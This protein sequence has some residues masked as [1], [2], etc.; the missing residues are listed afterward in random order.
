MVS[1]GRDGVGA[2]RPDLPEGVAIE[3][4]E[5]TGWTSL[6]SARRD[7]AVATNVTRLVLAK[8]LTLKAEILDLGTLVTG[9]P[10]E[11]FRPAPPSPTQPRRP[12]PPATYGQ[13][14]RIEDHGTPVRPRSLRYESMAG[15]QP[16]PSPGRTHVRTFA[17]DGIVAS[18]FSHV[19]SF[20]FGARRIGG[21]RTY[22]GVLIDVSRSTVRR[23][24]QVEGR[25]PQRRG[26]RYYYARG[27]W[28]EPFAHT[29]VARDVDRLIWDRRLLDRVMWHGYT[30]PAWEK[31]ASRLVAYGLRAI[32]AWIATGEIVNKVCRQRLGA[33]PDER[34]SGAAS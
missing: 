22:E 18:D 20:F 32:Q 7:P 6:P 13:M 34:P 2:D 16:E 28:L 1:P 25:T 5:G 3:D 9:S 30:G 24:S 19:G 15:E 14:V 33:G 12:R 31:F 8:A 27:D 29:G 21:R 10:G 26:P 11:T 4:C 17:Y 23:K